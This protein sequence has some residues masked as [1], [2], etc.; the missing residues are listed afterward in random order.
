M[1]SKLTQTQIVGLGYE[2]KKVRYKRNEKDKKKKKKI[3]KRAVIKVR[4]LLSLRN[5]IRTNL[6]IN[7]VKIT[8]G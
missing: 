1:N 4:S 6:Y 8:V 3:Y 7:T 2:W 5:F